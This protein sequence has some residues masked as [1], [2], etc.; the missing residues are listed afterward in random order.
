MSFPC[1]LDQAD[2]KNIEGTVLGLQAYP[3]PTLS[4]HLSASFRVYTGHG[5]IGKRP[6][7]GQGMKLQPA[8][9]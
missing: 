5:G 3:V 9:W 4:K 1:R 6:E 8:C 7:G 2:R